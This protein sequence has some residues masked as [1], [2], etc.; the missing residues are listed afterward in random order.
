MVF[1]TDEQRKLVEVNHNLIYDFLFKHHLTIEDWYDL[2][3]IGLCKAVI[4]WD[5]EKSQFS[6]YAYRL[7]LNEVLMEKRKNRKQSTIP[8]YKMVYYQ[9]ETENNDGDTDSFMN[10]LPSK[11]NVEGDVLSEV[12]FNE[13]ENNLKDRHKKIFALFRQGYK[14]R[15]I[16]KIVGCSQPQVSR[17]KKKFAN[18][19][20]S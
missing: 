20:V 4:S 14:Q 16:C 13:F 17:V 2:A 10:F 1:I 12:M 15:E 19:L 5:S 11:E 3:A 18:Y 9:D 6:T 8:E 7:M